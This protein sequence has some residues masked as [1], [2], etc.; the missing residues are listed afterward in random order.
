MRLCPSECNVK[1]SAADKRAGLVFRDWEGYKYDLVK[2]EPLRVVH[3]CKPDGSDVRYVTLVAAACL[4]DGTA[5][6]HPEHAVNQLTRT[7][8]F[9]RCESD[10][11]LQLDL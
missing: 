2:F 4:R 9:R 3:C 6:T 1:Q 5:L 8:L 10:G 11:V 7:D